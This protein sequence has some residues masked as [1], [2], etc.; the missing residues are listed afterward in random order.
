MSSLHVVATIPV[1]P[2]SAELASAGLSQLAQA[3]REEEGCI[4]YVLYESAAAPGTFVTVEEWRS[5][6]DLDAHLA[7]PHVAQAFSD[8]GAHLTGEVA[9]HPLRQV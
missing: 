1:K 9:V 3:T 5:Q 8:F 4:S 2:E 6:D 7:S